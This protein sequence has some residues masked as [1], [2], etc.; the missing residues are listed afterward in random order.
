MYYGNLPVNTYYN[1]SSEC[2]NIFPDDYPKFLTTYLS[3]INDMEQPFRMLYSSPP[4]K[5]FH[6]QDP[7]V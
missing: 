3:Y 4:K 6:T 5:S 1:E 7:R 2:P